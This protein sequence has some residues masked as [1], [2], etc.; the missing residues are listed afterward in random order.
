MA[1]NKQETQSGAITSDSMRGRQAAQSQQ[2]DKNLQ[3]RPV[4]SRDVMALDP[5]QLKLAQERSE[6][7]GQKVSVKALRTVHKDPSLQGEVANPGDSFETTRGRAAELRSHGI[8]EFGS[9]QEERDA[10]FGQDH[11]A[12]TSARLKADQEARKIPDMHK[13]S[14]LRNP[15]L[16]LAEPQG[17]VRK[18][19][20]R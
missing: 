12:S 6:H 13:S 7:Q 9:E 4:T 8:V 19:S 5:Q 16:K 17:D 18:D 11:V 14:P 1:E 20:K 2:V 10:H 3:E 15:E